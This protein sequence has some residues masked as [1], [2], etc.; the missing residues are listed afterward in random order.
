MAIHESFA[1]HPQPDEA[2]HSTPQWHLEL[3]QDAQQKRNPGTVV[4][5]AAEQTVDQARRTVEQGA[6]QTVRE[7]QQ[8]VKA[9]R[10]RAEIAT[11]L[12]LNF[13]QIDGSNRTKTRDGK[14]TRNEIIDFRKDHST[15]LTSNELR[16]L[17][18][19]SRDFATQ[20]GRG[21]TGVN[22]ADIETYK[23]S[24]PVIIRRPT[25]AEDEGLDDKI[26][27]KAK[28]IWKGIRRRVGD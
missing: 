5:R 3:Q 15:S 4:E 9:A 27:D 1:F 25:Q 7:T 23:V 16:T 8:N 22:R 24:P 10:E 2:L 14:I 19:A 13:D 12:V 17:D 18:V 28:G 11:F 26:K 21:K 20:I 6:R